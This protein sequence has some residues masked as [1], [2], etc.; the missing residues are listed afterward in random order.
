M[1][2]HGVSVGVSKHE[3]P[4]KW[5]I[6]RLSD[7]SNPGMDKPIV[8]TLRVIGLEPQC[9]TPAETLDRLQVN[10]RLT[11]GKG[12]RSG[13]K[14]HRSWRALGCPLQAQLLRIELC[15]HLQV[16]DLQCDEV[17]SEDSHWRSS[18][19][20]RL[21]DNNIR[22]PDTGKMPTG[23]AGE[24]V[25]RAEDMSGYLVK[26]AQSVIHLALEEIVS[27]QGLGIPHYVVL[28][29]LAETPGLPNAEL[30]RKAFVTPQSMNEAL[31]QLE[32]SGLVQR[33]QSP[34]D[35]RVL[36]AHLTHIGEHTW[37]LVNDR[38]R[39][40]EERLLS[41]LTKEEVRALN[42]SLKTII[43]NMSSTP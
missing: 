3:R 39:Q 32:A 35:A 16:A 12:N 21:P 1:D 41:G 4:A 6:E 29:L 38:V 20:I 15:R 18:I 10:G 42:R 26:R 9:D 27:R 5:T 17:G 22:F 25:P 31:K 24:R 7:D 37:R 23:K 40:L 33:R 34:A 28:T 13:D 19:I 36:N 2:G 11:N 14:D 8:Q 30:A 43:R